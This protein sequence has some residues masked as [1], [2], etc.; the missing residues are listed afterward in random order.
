[1]ICQEKKESYFFA[2]VPGSCNYS[3]S[4]SWVACNSLP[5]SK[6]YYVRSR[7]TIT[8]YQLDMFPS[9]LKIHQYAG[10][11][12]VFSSLVIV[13]ASFVTSGHSNCVEP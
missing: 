10:F 1:M 6:T 7:V 2:T 5:L 4:Y 3:L 13:F 11:F 12:I 8:Y 9:H